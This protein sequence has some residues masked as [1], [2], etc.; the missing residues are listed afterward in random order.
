MKATYKSWNI[1]SSGG[2]R[3]HAIAFGLNGDLGQSAQKHAGREKMLAL[4]KG[5]EKY[6]RRL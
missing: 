4:Q 3:R 2:E 5:Q 6:L 1:N